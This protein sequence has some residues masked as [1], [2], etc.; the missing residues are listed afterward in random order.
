MLLMI[1]IGVFSPGLGEEGT[2][3]GAGPELDGTIEARLAGPLCVERLVIEAARGCFEGFGLTA[4]GFNGQVLLFVLGE[5][6]KVQEPPPYWINIISIQYL[7][8]QIF[9]CSFSKRAE[10]C[11]NLHCAYQ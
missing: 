2:V 7:E 5:P 9:F 3:L 4:L 10:S 1:G 8:K 6:H 11:S